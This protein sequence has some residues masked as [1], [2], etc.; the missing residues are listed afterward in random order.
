VNYS[1]RGILR[2]AGGSNHTG[3]SHGQQVP[4]HADRPGWYR[5]R[6][7]REPGAADGR[8]I[9]ELC[10]SQC[11]RWNVHSTQRARV[12]D[13]G[14]GYIF[15]SDDG[16]F[17]RS[18]TSHIPVDSP[19]V[20]EPDPV[21]RP[22]VHDILA[23]ARTSDPV[24]ATISEINATIVTLHF[25]DGTRGDSDLKANGANIDPGAPAQKASIS[26]ASGGG[27]GCSLIGQSGNPAQAGTWWLLV[28]LIAL[29]HTR[30]A[31]GVLTR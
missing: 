14:R 25:V 20:N 8:N 12:R 26:G 5:S 16:D 3:V 22:N 17:F 2:T 6:T 23:M 18:D 13:S 21:N 11:L 31:G 4:A 15:K 29:L 19:V 24:S 1:P 30:S 10:K 9:P 27:G 28:A 7:V